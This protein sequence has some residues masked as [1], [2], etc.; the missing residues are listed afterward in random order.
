MTAAP[1]KSCGTCVMCCKVLDIEEF[2]KPAGLLCSNCGI[3]GG[4]HIYASRPQVCRDYEC[5]WLTE[6]SYPP[7]LKPDRIGTLLMDDPDSDEYHAVCDPAKPHAWRQ[8]IVMKHLI[9]KAKEGRTVVAKAGLM[10]W[11]IYDSGEIAPWT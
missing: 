9:S 1:G 3:K 5:L 6:R 10:A 7:T 11:R 4:C 8:P 2:N